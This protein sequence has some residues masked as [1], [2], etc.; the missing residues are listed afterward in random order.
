MY[1][2]WGE[3]I[4]LL[5]IDN[6]EST[7]R[8]HIILSHPLRRYTESPDMI[9]ELLWLGRSLLEWAKSRPER[10]VMVISADLSHTH[11]PDGPYGY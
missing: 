9:P 2:R 3:V 8:R 1:L 4:P 11:R 6:A 10:I 5:I 7:S